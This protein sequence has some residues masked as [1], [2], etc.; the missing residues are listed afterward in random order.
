MVCS[1]FIRKMR[2]CGQ[3]VMVREGRFIF[4][5]DFQ[6]GRG[7]WRFQRAMKL[8]RKI[9]GGEMNTMVSGIR[10]WAKPWR[11]WRPTSPRPNRKP[12]AVSDVGR[13]TPGL[14]HPTRQNPSGAARKHPAAPAAEERL[15]RDPDRPEISSWPGP[16]KRIAWDWKAD[17]YGACDARLPKERPA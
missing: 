2:R 4:E 8:R 17:S 11:H 12:P 6:N 5:D 1:P 14:L 15:A 7:G 10:A 13:R 9:R 16:A 3:R